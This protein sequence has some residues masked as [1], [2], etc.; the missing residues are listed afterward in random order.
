MWQM[1]KVFINTNLLLLSKDI[2]PYVEGYPRPHHI[3]YQGNQTL[4]NLIDWMER[5]KHACRCYVVYGHTEAEMWKKLRKSY[6][7]VEAAGG[8]VRNDK[9]K[10]LFIFRNNV[11]DLPKG[12]LDPGEM[13]DTAAIREVKEECGVSNL[14]ITAYLSETY[15]TYGANGRRKLKRTT[16][17][18][19]QSN[20]KHLVPQT[21]EGITDIK[22]IAE[23]KLHKVLVN[24]YPGILEVLSREINQPGWHI[25]R[26]W[27]P[28]IGFE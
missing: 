17:F 3:A 22:W 20:D 23:K 24:T 15:H 21:E 7:L 14:K 19:M 12:K 4:S 25:L 11:W 26:E 13:P 18:R 16:W 9:G 5:E 10:I 1:Y 6:D 2:P 27:H 28:M 8:L